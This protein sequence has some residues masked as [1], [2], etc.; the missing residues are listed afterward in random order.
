[1]QKIEF[2]TRA[3]E[4]LVARSLTLLGRPGRSVVTLKA[5]TGS[6][7]TVMMAN[8]LAALSKA[9]EGR[10][11]L[12]ILWVAPN[13][14]HEQSYERLKQV[15]GESKVLACVNADELSGTELPERAVVFMNWASIDS[16]K[17]VLRRDNETGRN[18][19][20]FIQRARVTGRKV[21]L[22]VDESH[23]H[24]DSGE[25]AQVVVDHIIAPDLL[26]EV[27]ATPKAERPDAPVVVLRE[28]VIAAGMI[29]KG[30]TVNPGADLSDE[31][32][33]FLPL[34]DGTSEALL[35]AALAKQ[36]ELTRQFKAVGSPVVPLVLVQLP[37]RKANANALQNFERYLLMKHGLERG[38]G[39]AVWLS[40]DRSPEI[41]AIVDFGSPVRVMF[42]KQAAATGWDCPRAQILVG[43]REMQ[44]DT[45][46]TQVLGRIIR[47]PERRHY[48]DEELNRAYVFTNYPKLEMD[49]ETASWVGKA[50][51][52]AKEDFVLHLPNWAA[53]HEDR[54]GYLGL[55]VVAEMLTGMDALSGVFHR[56]E[57]VASMLYDLAVDD[58]DEHQSHLGQHAVA[59]DIPGLQQ[60]LD[61]LK[62]E[63]MSAT[64]S[65][66]KGK[67]YIEKALRDAAMAISGTDDEK[68]VLETILHTQNR[69]QFFA[70]AEAG[71]LRFQAGQQKPERMFAERPNW[72][73]PASRFI[74]LSEPLA[75]YSKC[76]YAPVLSGQFE[77]SDVEEPFS[78]L[79]DADPAVAV[80]LKNGDHGQEHFAIKYELYGAEA[81]FYPDFLVKTVTGGIRLYD[82][83]GAG[84][85]EL[86]TGNSPDTH[87]KARALHAYTQAL[88]EQGVDVSGGIVVRRDDQWFLHKGEDY[89]G[90]KQLEPR[91]PGY[92]W[93]P[94]TVP[95][96]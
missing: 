15:Y 63:L 11:N 6:G 9:C 13:K 12:A 74:E 38:N 73:A 78:R 80:W 76:L 23:L 7:K 33:Q 43:L 35:D 10:H 81:L 25:Q 64:G 52:Q 8:A 85:T 19:A 96:G 90:S 29:R 42:F 71:I 14:L 53:R 40:G 54:R 57:V 16:D 2:Q 61:E 82:T 18:L 70:F 56:G 68:T 45:F 39:L 72:T 37:D 75:S 92:G 24:L 27:S 67:K 89:S 91:R 59:L 65:Q 95:L 58:I 49:A 1:M 46:T 30:I 34:Y 55:G 21:V 79:L 3:Q 22:V 5:P 4:D 86:S 48:G 47:Q 28:D 69:A 77:R 88:R 50:L 83:K 31:G 60:R 44:S 51:V 66:N 87:A 26:I 36:A 32:G 94:F 84:D 20:S 17:L 41:D 93:T 62:N